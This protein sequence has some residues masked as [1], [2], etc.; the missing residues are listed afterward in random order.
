[1]NYNEKIL[2]GSALGFIMIV[3]GTLIGYIIRL[4]LSRALTVEEFG[5][6]YG[7]LAF[8][9]IFSVL[10]EVGLKEGLIKYIPQ[11]RVQKDTSS[12]KSIISYVLLV[13]ILLAT[14]MMVVFVLLSDYIAAEY[15]HNAG[16][17][18][19]LKILGIS[20]ALFI[21]I[22]DATS[23]FSGLGRIKLLSYVSPVN[24]IVFMVFVMLA[25]ASISGAAY[26]YLIS[27]VATIFIFYLIIFRLPFFSEGKTTF[28]KNMIKQIM[29]FSIPIFMIS[30]LD[31]L[32]A[33]MDTLIL[34]YFRSLEEVGYYQVAM[35]T[36]RLLLV[37]Y[38]ATVLV[39]FPIFSEMW[40]RKDKK[41]ISSSISMIL[42]YMLIV[43]LPFVMLA[44]A[45]PNEIIRMLFGV[46]YL[47]AAPALQILS[48]S[49]VFL[50]LNS[51]MSTL[52][53]ATGKIRLFAKMT[54]AIFLINLSLNLALVPY[55]GIIGASIATTIS[56]FIAFLIY[57][58]FV[59]KEIRISFRLADFSRIVALSFFVLASIA[60]MKTLLDMNPWAEMAI[61]LVVSS[62]LYGVLLILSK[63]ITRKDL[64]LLYNAKVSVPNW[65]K[66]LLSKIVRD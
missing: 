1:M 66:N 52:F 63:T 45:F 9:G 17:S 38:S 6:F 13:H 61:S 16:A 55:L 3:V 42:K 36:S 33:Q 60:L 49:V 18:L 25:A 65:L 21:F 51:I 24:N 31:S 59:E 19:I 5:L 46:K 58:Y 64:E 26:A 22:R 57:L 50:T 29:F 12:V 43:I 10:C 27:V 37:F 14:V 54:I 62:V 15:F 41:G 53:V 48:F 32:T 30:F 23:I 44:I 35:P 8:T 39:I 7:V 4:Y 47:P 20:G 40:A 11:F 2:K 34:T 28:N 56:L